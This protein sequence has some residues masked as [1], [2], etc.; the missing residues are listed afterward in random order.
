MSLPSEVTFFQPRSQYKRSDPIYY[1]SCVSPQA[2]SVWKPH[3]HS[4][5]SVFCAVQNRSA[6]L[7]L[8]RKLL[9]SPPSRLSFH[10]YFFSD[11]QSL[12]KFSEQFL[13]ICT[14]PWALS[15]FFQ[16][17]YRRI[18]PFIAIVHSWLKWSPWHLYHW[19]RMLKTIRVQMK[20]Q[21]SKRLYLYSQAWPFFEWWF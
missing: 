4:G 19:T 10:C 20:H 2:V 5:R 15:W 13:H 3:S 11:F 8:A 12:S 18:S 7:S 9:H 16:D 17:V 21:W 1:R 6:T 14:C